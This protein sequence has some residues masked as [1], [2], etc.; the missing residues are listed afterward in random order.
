MSALGKRDRVLADRPLNQDEESLLFSDTAAVNHFLEPTAKR[1]KLLKPD[2]VPAQ[3]VATSTDALIEESNKA[4]P[5]T[6]H[7]DSNSL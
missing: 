4:E 3:T 6:N 2:A 1:R 5:A 7:D